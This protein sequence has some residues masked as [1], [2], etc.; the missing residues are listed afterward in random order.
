MMNEFKYEGL[1]D[2]C[3]LIVLVESTNMLHGDRPSRLYEFLAS[4]PLCTD[5][6]IDRSQPLLANRPCKL[7]MS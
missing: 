6:P 3:C 4:Y 7:L 2:T 5:D 1:F